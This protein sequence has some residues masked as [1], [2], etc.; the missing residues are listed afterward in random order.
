VIAGRDLSN[1]D[2]GCA[3]SVCDSGKLAILTRVGLRLMGQ[4]GL[5]WSH[6]VQGDSENAFAVGRPP[7]PPRPARAGEYSAGEIRAAM[8]MLGAWKRANPQEG[9]PGPEHGWVRGYIPGFEAFVTR[10]NAARDRL[11]ARHG[12]RLALLEGAEF[13][14]YTAHQ[15]LIAHALSRPETLL[16]ATV[17]DILY[18]CDV[19]S[20]TEDY[21]AMVAEMA[22]MLRLLKVLALLAGTTGRRFPN[23][24]KLTFLLALAMQPQAQA[25]VRS[26]PCEPPPRTQRPPGRVVLS[27]P[28]VARA[29]GAV[30]PSLSTTVRAAA[31]CVRSEGA[32]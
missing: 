31:D 24:L 17:E 8:R 16:T 12:K 30:R 2:S 32:L 19:P 26:I 1:A 15:E 27:G 3:Q 29:P 13:L 10:D 7:S 5:T 22:V 9:D 6:V 25:P 18:L 23:L 11:T 14:P 21:A 4:S 20:Y 28:R